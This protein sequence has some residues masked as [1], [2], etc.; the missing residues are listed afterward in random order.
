MNLTPMDIHNKQ[1]DRKMRG[2]DADQVDG[3]LDRVVD[4]YGDALDQ[5]V[6]LKNA[7]QKLQEQV[8]HYNSVKDNLNDSLIGAQKSAR[9]V[10]KQA[11]EQAD[12]V[13]ADAKKQ[14]EAKNKEMQAQY[15]SLQ[16]DYELLKNK[17]ADFRH[18]LQDLLQ[19]Q[20]KELGDDDWQ[21]FLDRYYGRNRL[22]PA[23]G[24]PVDSAK[25][26]AEAEPKTAAEKAAVDKEQE[27]DLESKQS[28]QPQILTG[29]S[30]SH[31]SEQP[32]EQTNV[33]GQGPQ[34]VFPD[35]YKDHQ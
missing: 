18:Q 10:K 2:Y 21:Y 16:S 3:F 32:E 14:A 9:A 35:N 26:N 19:S 1:F 17:V 13:L 22:Y 15:D 29:D 4:A 24:E 25:V 7:N 12:Q 27:A 28:D 11:Q 30:P 6:D 5:V 34:I 31:E 23:D 8:D 20:T 33:A